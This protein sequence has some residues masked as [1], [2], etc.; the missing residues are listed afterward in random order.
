MGAIWKVGY[1][2][3]LICVYIFHE[4]IPRGH[5]FKGTDEYVFIYIMSEYADVAY[6]VHTKR[7]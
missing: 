1:R 5:T 6:G 3:E 7:G 2:T 4:D